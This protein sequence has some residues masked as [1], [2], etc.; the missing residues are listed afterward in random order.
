MFPPEQASGEAT[1]GWASTKLLV[2]KELVDT[3]A[4]KMGAQLSVLAT[5]T[6]AQLEG[7]RYKHPL[8][9]R[10]S[11]IVIGGDYITTDAGTGL[12]HTAPGHGQVCGMCGK[13]LRLKGSVQGRP[14]TAAG[15]PFAAAQLLPGSLGLQHPRDLELDLL[16]M[17]TQW[18]A[19]ESLWN[20]QLPFRS[21]FIL[22]I[23]PI[24]PCTDQCK[25][26]DCGEMA[27]SASDAAWTLDL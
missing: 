27:K 21:E 26:L 12:V 20:T 19:S 14:E 23:L 6:G 8:Y 22:P 17:G 15:A 24:S 7:C 13:V 4:G 1:E 16:Y 9:E 11:P 18:A 3:I 10:E 25:S 5:L 2:A